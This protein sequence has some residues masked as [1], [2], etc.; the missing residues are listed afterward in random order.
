M[1]IFKKLTPF[2]RLTV[3]VLAVAI[4]GFVGYKVTDGGKNVNLSFSGS[5]YDA[6]IIVDTYTGWA[7]IVWGNGGKEGSTESL[8]YKNFGVKLKILNMDDFDAS[9]QAWKQDPSALAFCTLDSYP[10]EASSSGTMTDARYFVIHNFSAGADAIV[11]TKNINTVADLKG[12]K[13]AFSEGTASHSLLLNTLEAAG[14]SGTDV[15]QVKTG[16][17]SDVATAFKA[18]QVDAAVVFTPDDE[19]CIS[20][21]PG[22]KVL[23]STK[24]INTLI[25]DG[26]LAH[27]EWLDKNPEKAKKI[28]EALMWANSEITFNES[29]YKEACQVF[30]REFDV[31]LEDV[32]STGQKINFATLQDNINWFGLNPDYKGVKAE[33]LYTKM[34]Q[35]YANL[36]LAKNTLTWNKISYW[37]YVDELSQSTSLTN[38]QTAVGTK[39]RSFTAP[40]QEIKNAPAISYKKVVI[41]FPVNG[42]TLDATAQ[43]IIDKEFLDIVQSF[44]QVYIRIEGNTDNTGNYDYNVDLSKRRAQAVVDYLVRSGMD[45]SRFVVVGNGPKNAIRDGV[46]GSDQRYRTTDL[47]LIAE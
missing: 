17:G 29:A 16:Y 38:N 36:G 26:F 12:K 24:Q 32:V 46:K 6:T 25:T 2:G 10:V 31:P 8:F 33:G 43:D 45:A 40:T 19:A 1:G 5:G 41:E 9:R 35:V 39:E 47:Q 13:I 21:V 28:M 42:C 14:L 22:T 34:S 11:V 27:K 18:K 3:I 20:S 23:V 30:S 37:A 7:P 15:E 44:N 4:L